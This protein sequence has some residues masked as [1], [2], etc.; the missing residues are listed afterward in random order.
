MEGV[1]PEAPAN[2]IL[3]PGGAIQCNGRMQDRDEGLG[4]ELEHPSDPRGDT[5]LIQPETPGRRRD[6]GHWLKR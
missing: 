3:L 6:I 1:V 2:Q 5:K 4:V